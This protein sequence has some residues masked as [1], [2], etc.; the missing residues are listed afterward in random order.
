[1]ENIIK[2][3]DMNKKICSVE[4]CSNKVHAR[5][6]CS[7]HLYQF[8]KYGKILKV[9]RADPN[10]FVDRGDYIGIMLRNWDGEEV[11][12]AVIDKTDYDKVA[13]YKWS[14]SGNYVAT[15]KGNKKKYLH[16]IILPNA[17]EKDHK[18]RNPLNNRR[19]NIRIC[20]RTENNQNTSL[21]SDSTSGVTGVYPRRN[22]WTAKIT[23]NKEVI[24]LGDFTDFDDA[25]Q[26]RK[27]A[28]Q[29]YFGEFAPN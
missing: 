6:Y 17:E 7:K 5:G 13:N 11:A 18:D 19:T 24:Y 8:N 14:L 20:N 27:E 12:E 26:A 25:V 4:G 29:E 1:M 2:R 22:G 10:R 9:T 3:D 16:Q 28:E 23:V 21:R 15:Y